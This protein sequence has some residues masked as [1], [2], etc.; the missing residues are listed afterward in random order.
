MFVM[1]GS[2]FA[3]AVA[4]LKQ[5]LMAHVLRDIAILIHNCKP[6]LRVR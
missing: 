4:R 2:L 6:T 5:N 1:A 3:R